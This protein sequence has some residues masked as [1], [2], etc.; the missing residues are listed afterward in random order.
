MGFRTI[1]LDTKEGRDKYKKLK[2]TKSV[3]ETFKEEKG[4]ENFAPRP[5]EEPKQD[6]SFLQQYEGKWEAGEL[7]PKQEESI[8]P[9]VTVQGVV[10]G[11]DQLRVRTKPEGEIMYLISSK[12]VVTI[13]DEYEGWYKVETAP[14]RVGWVMKS[15]IQRY[16]EGG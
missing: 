15:Y 3:R 2:E 6:T 8:E 16:S 1:D 13:L 12:S 11:V 10:T 9:K 4:I 5:E 7:P 14:G